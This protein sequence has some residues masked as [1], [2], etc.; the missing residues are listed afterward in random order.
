MNIPLA[1]GATDTAYDV[2]Y[3]TIVEA[4]LG[5][6]QYRTFSHGRPRDDE[7]KQSMIPR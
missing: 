3:K 5:V 6:G 1:A 7:M 4:Q 2:A